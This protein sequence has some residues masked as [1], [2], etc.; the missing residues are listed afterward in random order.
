M[1][2]DSV[3]RVVVGTALLKDTSWLKE[4]ME[5]LG[6]RVVAAVDVRDRE[7]MV[8]GWRDGSGGIVS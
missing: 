4:A 1:A 5:E 3:A 6:D 7:V 2:R 8:E